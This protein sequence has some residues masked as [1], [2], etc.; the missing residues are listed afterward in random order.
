[1]M[2]R[3]LVPQRVFTGR[4]LS[5]VLYRGPGRAPVLLLVFN[6]YNILYAVL[7]RVSGRVLVLLLVFNQYGRFYV[8]LFGYRDTLYKSPVW[9]LAE[10]W[11]KFSYEYQ[12][13]YMH[14]SY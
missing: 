4:V 10:P 1:V 14:H 7:Y 3:Q 13:A 6:Q 2:L 8:I 11:P 9:A 12:W 5:S